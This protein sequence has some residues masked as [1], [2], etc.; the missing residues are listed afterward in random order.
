[1]EI[2]FSDRDI[3]NKLGGEV[4][5]VLYTDLDQYEDIDELLSPYGRTVILYEQVRGL[6]HW[7]CLFRGPGKNM[8]SYFDSYGNFVDE[9]LDNIHPEYRSAYGD[10]RLLSAMLLRAKK[11]GMSIDYNP[12]QMQEHGDGINTCGPWVVLRL[13]YPWLDAEEFARIF[14]PEDRS[15]KPDELV[16]EMMRRI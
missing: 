8:V 16:V 15:I 4:K 9:P 11:G 14:T 1:M 7:T 3:E 5:V 12:Y 10:T 6:G 2:L 13:T